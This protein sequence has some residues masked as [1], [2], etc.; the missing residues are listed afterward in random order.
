MPVRTWRTVLDSTTASVGARPQA[1]WLCEEASGAFGNDFDEVL[2]DEPTTRMMVH[3]AAMLERHATGEPLQYVLGHWS[4]RHLDLLVDQRVLIPRPE[5]EILAGLAIDLMRS[6]L[7][8]GQSSVR[9]V[10]LGTGSGAIGLSLALELPRGA[11]EVW[12]CDRS[13]DALDVARANLAGL[14]VAGHGVR[15]A[16][17]SWFEALPVDLC[18]SLDLVAANPPYVA[19]GDPDVDAAVRDWEPAAAV[20][21]GPDGLEAHRVICATAARWLRPGGWLVCEIGSTQGPDVAALMSDA[22]LGDVEVRPDLAGRDRI[23]T[24]RRP[25]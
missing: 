17:G 19:D 11:A 22:G 1:R 13:S 14:G 9:C 15:V 8:G 10:D 23:V 4:F 6:A 16:Q 5:T 2:D 7:A 20:W 18:G 24:G 21:S 12:L 25:G 3:L